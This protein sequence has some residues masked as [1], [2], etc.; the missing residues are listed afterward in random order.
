VNPE[1]TEQRFSLVGPVANVSAM[2][3]LSQEDLGCVEQ[4]TAE[5]EAKIDSLGYRSATLAELLT[6]AEETWNRDD[7]VVALGSLGLDQCEA[8]VVP[9]L[10]AGGDRRLRQ[11]WGHSQAC[12]YGDNF[13]FLV[14]RK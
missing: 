8:L 9:Y 11:H 2:V 12:W 13:H 5:Y 7:S 3:A 1:I 14:V 4:T 10:C 6:W